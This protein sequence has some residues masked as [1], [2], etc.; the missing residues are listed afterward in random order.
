MRQIQI[1]RGR[2]FYLCIKLHSAIAAAGN[3][4]AAG[5]T[6]NEA[7][8]ARLVSVSVETAMRGPA[9]A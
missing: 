3:R 4:L 7:R 9:K 8:D 6:S 1:S 2:A 5:A